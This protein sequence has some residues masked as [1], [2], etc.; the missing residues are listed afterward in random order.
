VGVN[1][2]ARVIEAPQPVAQAPQVMPQPL[3]TMF[4]AVQVPGPDGKLWVMVQFQT[5]Q[6][7]TVLFFETDAARK[8]GVELQKLG[9]AG[10]ILLAG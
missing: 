7:N 8:I 9:S 4:A 10:D 5:P 6:G 3:P 2:R 1:G